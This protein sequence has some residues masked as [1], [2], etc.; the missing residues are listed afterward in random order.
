MIQLLLL[1]HGTQPQFYYMWQ[2]LG[3]SKGYITITRDWSLNSLYSLLLVLNTPPSNPLVLSC[4]IGCIFICD[5]YVLLKRYLYAF[6]FHWRYH[7]QEIL[8]SWYYTLFY[9]KACAHVLQELTIINNS[10]H[11][12]AF[13]VALL[14]EIIVHWEKLMRIQLP[15]QLCCWS[16]VTWHCFTGVF[17]NEI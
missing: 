15:Q 2:F 11:R 16:D 12:C 1:H 6:L 9:M 17:C 8:I 14:V 5:C 10:P 7:C 4:Y 3:H 13:S